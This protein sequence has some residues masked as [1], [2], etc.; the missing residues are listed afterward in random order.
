MAR[1]LKK[2]GGKIV[3]AILLVIFIS[4]LVYWFWWGATRLPSIGRAPDFTMQNLQGEPV[5]FH[6]STG[7]IRVVE[8][9]YANC[10][11]ICPITTANLVQMQNEIKE[12]DP[13][14]IGNRIEFWA[15]TF[16]PERDTPEVLQQYADNIGMDPDLWQV[17][18]GTPAE[19]IQIADQFGAYV[20]KEADG[21]FTHS[22]KSLFLV[23]GANNIRRV[24]YMGDKMPSEEILDDVLQLAHE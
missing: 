21:T 23:D 12:D 7:K 1:F 11:D 4:S 14:L 13:K 18:R 3:I 2:Y 19:T 17:V 22:T 20:A 10:P 24:Y 6:D 15:I 9:F 16:D 8:F 5:S